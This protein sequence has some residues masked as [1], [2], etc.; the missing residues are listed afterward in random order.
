MN[1]V[2][3]LKKSLSFPENET[4]IS[5]NRKV[6]IRIST[7]QILTHSEKKKYQFFVVDIIISHE[8][9]VMDPATC[10]QL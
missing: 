7:C 5:V 8:N 2:K 1:E 6:H 3:L 10:S 9:C 4:S